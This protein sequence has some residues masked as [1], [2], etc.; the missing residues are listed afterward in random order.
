MIG[1][2]I[3]GYLLDLSHIYVAFISYLDKHNL[4]RAEKQA[5][6]NDCQDRNRSLSII[7]AKVYLQAVRESTCPKNIVPKT[8]HHFGY[9]KLAYCIE[10]HL[11]EPP[12]TQSAYR[13]LLLKFTIMLEEYR[14]ILLES[15]VKGLALLTFVFMAALIGLNA[16][17]SSGLTIV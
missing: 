8:Q 11:A 3:D 15:F 7:S 2:F 5:V 9:T 14:V 6:K 10:H 4:V 16:F 17:I 13:N 1:L 12:C